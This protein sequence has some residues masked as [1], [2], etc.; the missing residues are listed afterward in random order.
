[1]CSCKFKGGAQVKNKCTGGF[2][3]NKA[4]KLGRKL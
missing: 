4:R 3:N 1:M 2:L